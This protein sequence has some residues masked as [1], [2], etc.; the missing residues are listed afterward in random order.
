MNRSLKAD[1]YHRVSI[2]QF[3][4]QPVEEEKIFEILRAAMQSPSTANQQPWEF[5]VVTD[6]ER[7]QRLGSIKGSSRHAS[8]APVCIVPA[9]R[10]KDGDPGWAQI[11]LSICMENMWLAADALGLGGVWIGVYPEE[12]TMKACEEICGIPEGQRAFGLF[13]LG[14]PAAS[15]EQEDR[16]K[17]ERIH[18]VK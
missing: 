18:F 6:A 14:Y 2:R 15:K 11:D 5:Y 4:D 13:P 9:Y 8:G 1:L 3:T 16:F 10:V 7:I 12:E 17:P